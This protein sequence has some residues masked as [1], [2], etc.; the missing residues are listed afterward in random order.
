VAPEFAVI[1]DV[2]YLDTELGLKL[3]ALAD[4]VRAG[5]RVGVSTSAKVLPTTQNRFNLLASTMRTGLTAR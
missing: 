3:A 4:A 1:F 2:D 5:D